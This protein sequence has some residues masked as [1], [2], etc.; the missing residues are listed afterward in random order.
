L[1]Y[2]DPFIA[3]GGEGFGVGCGFPGAARPFGLVKVSPDTASASGAAFGAYRGGGY[4]STDS[5]IRGFS[6]IHLHGVGLTDYGLVSMMPTDGMSAELIDEDPRRAPFRKEEE[7]ARPG[8]YRV[9]LDDPEVEVRLS[10]TDRTALHRYAYAD[11]VAEP[12]VVIDLSHTMGDARVMAAE[13]TIDPAGAFEGWMQVDGDM[14]SP[15]TIYFSARM[16]DPP[17]VWGTWSGEKLSERST[18]VSAA[19]EA[20]EGV[21]VGGYLQLGDDLARIR[22]GVSMVDLPGARANLAA[23]DDGH[24]I[25]VSAHNAYE[26]WR[27]WLDVV[28]V[29]G[30]TEDQ[31]TIFATALYH[32][33]L[34]PTRY[35]DVDGRY[36]GFD[37]AIH[38]DPGHPYHTD[39]SLWD[40]YRTTHPLYTLLWPA[41][42]RVLLRSLARM[43]E[44]G[45]SLPKWPIANW[46][47]GFMVGSP[48][49]IVAAEAAQKE[50]GAFDEQILIDNAVGMA[51][52]T[53]GT[54]YGG[55][56]DPN[57]Y[58]ELEYIAHDEGGASVAWTQE[59][60][61]ADHA[62]GQLG[63]E[64]VDP[65]TAATL[66]ERGG[67]WRNVYDPAVGYFHGRLASGEFAEF[68]SDAAW[69]DE[70]AEGN[71][72]Q[73]LWF[74][75]HDA[76]GLFAELGGEDVALERLTEFFERGA[77]EHEEQAEGIPGTW[78]WHG[79]EIDLQAAWLFSLAGRPD[80]GRQWV[81]WV[82]E[83]QYG[84]GANGLAGNDD[85]GTLSAWYVWAAMGLY[86]LAGTDQYV[87][88]DPIFTRVEIDREHAPLTILR[89]G[90]AD[91]DAI[92][93]DGETL[94]VSIDHA[95]LQSGSTLRFSGAQ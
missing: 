50:L 7:S 11:T 27:P 17:T 75:P 14:T 9:Q 80:L 85:G 84:T 46:D 57:R 31:R 63:P 19:E 40:T 91:V 76:P 28:A 35:N 71:A 64:L 61:L 68:A 37:G 54:P 39:F 3:T 60:A 51:L 70:Y 44:Q 81:R 73:Y 62:L 66:A 1:S 42:H 6:H 86:P 82:M 65:T 74:V 8:Y 53:V 78:Y 15:Y 52:G 43:V 16:D 69:L 45:G 25:T 24:D 23:E 22:V 36:P 5:T 32:S 72:R 95:T 58:A 77:Q 13:L 49:H 47:G 67:W 92:D 10:A 12:T 30:G 79:N 93:L 94:D 18:T 33:L 59:L 4:H 29:W 89:T 38:D 83:S 56:P 55:R 41:T 48:A 88:G 90:T 20:G 21:N 34:M 26:A 2:V 87:L